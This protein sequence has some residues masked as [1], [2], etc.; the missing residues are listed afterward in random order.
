[1]IALELLSLL[2]RSGGLGCA[3]ILD[4]PLPGLTGTG[5]FEEEGRGLAVGFG[6]AGCTLRRLPWAPASAVDAPGLE[7]ECCREGFGVGFG[8]AACILR[9]LLDRGGL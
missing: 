9:G 5:S 1:M 3:A 2:D 4:P 6:A 7:G 8:A